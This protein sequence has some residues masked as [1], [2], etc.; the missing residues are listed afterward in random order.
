MFAGLGNKLA[1]QQAQGLYRALTPLMA[2]RGSHVV[3]DGH[4][5][6][7]LCSNDYLGLAQHP[8]L[9]RAAAEAAR[10]WGVGSSA[11]RLVSGTLCLHEELERRLAVF[12]GSEAALLFNSGYQ[13]N[14]GIISTL[15]QEGDLILSDAL[16]HASIIDACRLSRAKTLVYRHRNADHL[17]SLLAA[18]QNYHRKLIITESIFSMDGDIAP[19]PELVELAKR[20]DARVLVDEAHS[21]GVLGN[22]GRGVCE[23]FGL[24]PREFMVM[25]TLSK[26]LGGFG[27]FLTSTKSVVAYLVNFSR[28]LLYT[29]ALPP[30]VVGAALAALEVLEEET[31][32]RDTLWKRAGW[33][34][35]ELQRAG[36]NTLD[37]KAQIIP[38]IVG[39][40][41]DAVLL[42]RKLLEQGIF[43]QAMRPPT[44]P[45]GTSRLRISLTAAH[46][47]KDLQ[48]VLAVL[49][50]TAKTMDLTIGG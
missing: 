48:H 37:S 9:I 15:M 43:I 23:Y 20:Y 8:R 49:V 18:S 24:D 46:E 36:F 25:G 10:T 21:T 6:I 27:A 29:T 22:R 4:E 30:S 40:A 42:A 50:D 44:V 34:R 47:E 3:I 28:P 14:L 41:E 2:R 12:K 13:A 33:F 17:E 1:E 19:L 5:V 11:S 45:P 38:I 26:A 7:N 16:N 31:W 32:R 35:Q 39:N